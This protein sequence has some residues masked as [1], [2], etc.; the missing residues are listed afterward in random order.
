MMAINVYLTV[1]KNYHASDLKKLEWRYILVCYGVPF[2]V[3]FTLCFCSSDSRG[4]IYGPAD[5]WCWISPNWDFLRIV[6]CYGPIWYAY[7]YGLVPL[8]T[9]P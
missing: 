5:L 2:I 7:I 4:K 9:S 6:V 3:G 1:F 8:L